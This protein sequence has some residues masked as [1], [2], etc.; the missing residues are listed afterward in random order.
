[1]NLLTSIQP[2]IHHYGYFGVALI[3]MFEMIG[4]PFPAETT[5]ILAGIEW[6]HGI[7]AFLPLLIAGII[8]N[9]VGSIIAY[10]IGRYLGRPF[11]LRFQKILRI[12]DDMLDRAQNKL[13]KAKIPVL[14]ISKFIAGIR[15]LVPYLAGINRLPFPQFLLWTSLGT[16]LWVLVF[17]TF[18]QTLGVFIKHG[19]NLIKHSP[20]LSISVL[21]VIGVA[22]GFWIRHRRKIKL[23]KRNKEWESLQ[24]DQS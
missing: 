5:L 18:G 14:V 22:I 6:K 7:F 19:V 15:I 23:I 24:N 8:G 2:L 21:A 9:I 1:V 3:L 4:I 11:L 16:S 17:I 13:L 20:F 12:N 10:T